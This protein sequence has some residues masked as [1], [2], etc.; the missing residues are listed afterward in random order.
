MLAWMA[1]IIPAAAI[2]IQGDKLLTHMALN[3]WHT[4]GLDRFFAMFTHLADGLVPTGLSFLL[5]F[6][7]GWRAF[8]MMGLTCGLSAIIAQTLKRGPFAHLDRPKMFRSELHGLDWVEGIDLHAHNSFPSGHTTAAFGMCLA[9]AVVL[10]RPRL[11]VPFALLAALLG[12]ARIYLSQHFLQDVAMGSAVG[13]LT[14]AGI[15][16]LVYLGPWSKQP[17]MEKR[18]WPRPVAADHR[19]L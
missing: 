2:A 4:P 6:T 14:G 8:L 15:F 7:R 11:A 9:L 13:T 16:W 12:Y 3:A 17:W 19:A 1:F 18:P 10:A 5:L